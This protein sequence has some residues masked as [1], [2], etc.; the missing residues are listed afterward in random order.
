MSAT[1]AMVMATTSLTATPRLPVPPVAPG[2][3]GAGP[4][5]VRA[6]VDAARARRS[7]S[8]VVIFKRRPAVRGPEAALFMVGLHAGEATV[9]LRASARLG[10]EARHYAL[11]PTK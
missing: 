6:A 4:M 5:A 11:L 9:A 7:L 10:V 1:I 2:R 3:P 8:A